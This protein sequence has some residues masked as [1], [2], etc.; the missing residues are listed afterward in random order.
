MENEKLYRSMGR[1]GAGNVVIGIILI[2][3]GTAA[4]ILSIVG[5]ARL[6]ARRKELSF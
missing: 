6:Y 1:I 2:A 3:V 5:G 4:G